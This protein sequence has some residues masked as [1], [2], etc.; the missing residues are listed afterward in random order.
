[1]EEKFER[2]RERDRKKEKR[3][4]MKAKMNLWKDRVRGCYGVVGRCCPTQKMISRRES[5]VQLSSFKMKE[6]L[7]FNNASLY[8][9]SLQKNMINQSLQ[10]G[11]I[12]PRETDGNFD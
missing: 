8:A 3:F 4:K 11:E 2:E 9:A 6:H 1:M 7:I 10:T 5:S 12:Y